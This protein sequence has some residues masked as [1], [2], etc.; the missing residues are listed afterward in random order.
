MAGDFVKV[1]VTCSHN[2]NNNINNNN[3]NNNG[4][5]RH[6]LRF[7]QPPHCAGNCFQHVYSSNQLVIGV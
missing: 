7:L 4:I 1:Q 6:N 5:E 3:N 2:N